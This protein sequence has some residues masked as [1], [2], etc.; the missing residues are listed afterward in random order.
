[1]SV[2]IRSALLHGRRATLYA[3]AGVV[4]GSR[5]EAELEETRLKL[6]PMLGALLEL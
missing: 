5:W 6:R 2:A 3:G 4:A 1:V